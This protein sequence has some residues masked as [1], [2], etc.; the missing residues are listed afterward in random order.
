[1]PRRLTIVA[2]AAALAVAASAAGCGG[3]DGG[4]GTGG[5]A[6]A[7]AGRVTTAERSAPH[8]HRRRAHRPP[9][10]RCDPAAANCAAAAGRIIALESKDPD[11]DGDLH[12]ILAGGSVTLRGVTVLD[13]SR[14]LRPRHDPRIGDWAAG[15]G[16]VY[17]GS[18]GQHQIQVERVVFFPRR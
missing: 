2:L 10:P 16:T 14:T 12:V 13:V 9:A 6:T 18:F 11:G 5:P 7:E 17:T 1:M 4:A 8:R 3:T 15:A